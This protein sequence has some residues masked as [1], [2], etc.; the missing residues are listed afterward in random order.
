MVLRVV[1]LDATICEPRK[2]LF[3]APENNLILTIPRKV[4]R[5]AK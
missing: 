1:R 3:M 5:N 2:T 4:N